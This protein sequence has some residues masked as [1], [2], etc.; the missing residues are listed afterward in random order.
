MRGFVF[1]RCGCLG[2]MMGAR[3]VIEVVVEVVVLVSSR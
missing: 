2:K 3:V 1:F